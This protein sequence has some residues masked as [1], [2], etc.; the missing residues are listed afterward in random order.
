[1]KTIVSILLFL[2][3]FNVLAEMSDTNLLEIGINSLESSNK[4]IA[5]TKFIDVHQIVIPHPD[6]EIQNFIT[7]AKAGD[8]DSFALIA[9]N[10]WTGG[11]G[12]R[13]NKLPANAALLRAIKDGSPQ[14]AAFIAECFL[15]SGRTAKTDDERI[16]A[17]LSGIGWY[18]ISAGLGEIQ[19]HDRA[20][21]FINEAG[22]T[23]QELRSGLIAMYDKGLE[24]SKLYK[25]DSTVK[26][27]KK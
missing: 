27:K 7:R 10:V 20:M 15:I 11:V 25:I 13:E 1:M 24:D 17:I 3:P 12:F 26:S 6:R 16:D 19:A 9:F 5:Y 4:K 23:N 21:D 22:K 18:G 8:S 2:L 14:A